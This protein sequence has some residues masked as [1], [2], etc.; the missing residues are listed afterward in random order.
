MQGAYV[1]LIDSN[2]NFILIYNNINSFF[3]IL[4]RYKINLIVEYK[5]EEG[6]FINIENYFLTVKSF[7][8]KEPLLKEF[9][10]F[11]ILKFAIRKIVVPSF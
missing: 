9:I 10:D 8:K 3:I 1:Y 2:F 11:L 5:A 4:R 7:K 6:Y